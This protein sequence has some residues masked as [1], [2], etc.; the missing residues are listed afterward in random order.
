M[1][2]AWHWL[3]AHYGIALVAFRK[4]VQT[5]AIFE[6]PCQSC[7]YQSHEYDYV[8]GQ[9]KYE[10]VFF[11]FFCSLFSLKI[12]HA[13]TCVMTRFLFLFSLSVH[14]PYLEGPYICH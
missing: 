7:K 8:H 4:K 14:V 10:V 1:T 2:H 12:N 6:I 5:R 3:A 9:L 11:L 13:G